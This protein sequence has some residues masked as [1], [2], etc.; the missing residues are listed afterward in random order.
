MMKQPM[1]RPQSSSLKDATNANEKLAMMSR[2]KEQQR[3]QYERKK[4][5]MSG[6]KAVGARTGALNLG[7]QLTLE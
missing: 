4:T 5:Q 7:G 2:L 3:L 6:M 1:N